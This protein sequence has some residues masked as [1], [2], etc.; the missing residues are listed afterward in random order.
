MRGTGSAGH[1]S[2][3]RGAGHGGQGPNQARPQEMGKR[4][5]LIPCGGLLT[6]S[7]PLLSRC[8]RLVCLTALY[9]LIWPTGKTLVSGLISCYL[10]GFV[11]NVTFER[12]SFLSKSLLF[13]PFFITAFDYFFRG[14]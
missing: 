8:F 11:L 14:T 6:I 13:S 9:E 2:N 1:M 3:A 5:D 7:L 12:P 10:S 4:L